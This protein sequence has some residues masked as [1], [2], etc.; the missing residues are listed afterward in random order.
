MCRVVE[1]IA[2]NEVA[3]SKLE[4]MIRSSVRVDPL[5]VDASTCTSDDFV[6]Y[7]ASRGMASEASVFLSRPHIVI[8][9]LRMTLD[10]ERRW[11]QEERLT[12][13]QAISRLQQS[14][15]ALRSVVP[16]D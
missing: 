13:L 3:I 8:E 10:Q 15:L 2:R 6:T 11:Q 9:K 16:H 4:E 5:V 7:D 1:A 14:A 12:Y